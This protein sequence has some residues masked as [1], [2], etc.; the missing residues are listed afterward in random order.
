MHVN[1]CEPHCS[2]AETCHLAR[3]WGFDG[4]E[5]RRADLWQRRAADSY[6]DELQ[7]AF[8][9][10]GLSSLI[11]GAP[12]IDLTASS[13]DQRRKNID[14]AIAFY[15]KASA[16]L[17]VMRINLLTGLLRHPEAAFFDWQRSGSHFATGEHWEWSIA[18]LRAIAEFLDA[19]GLGAGIENHLNYLHD[20][21]E[22]TQRLVTQ[23]G[24]PRLGY[25]LDLGN[26]LLMAPSPS[27]DEILDRTLAGAVTLHIKNHLET[28]DGRPIL[29]RLKDGVINYRHV[30]RRA[31]ESGFDGPIVIESAA[32]G[33]RQAWAAEDLA[34]L[35][36]LLHL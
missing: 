13:H 15:Q 32:S 35:K 11:L 29:G 7:R 16:A 8:D 24:S 3:A 23:A 21:V 4:V 25:T 17:P 30:L 19:Q 26:Y 9:G 33:D 1:Y 18:G 36:T 12:A 28:L 14:E 2:L 5:L 27:V 31:A 22:A 10:S 20:T 34:Y 6:F